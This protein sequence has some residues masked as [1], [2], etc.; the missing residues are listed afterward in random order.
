MIINE[1]MKNE[2][3]ILKQNI[4]SVLEKCN[5]TDLQL[6]NFLR[7]LE[8]ARYNVLSEVKLYNKN[9]EYEYEKIKTIDDEYKAE[10][11]DDEILKIYVPETMPSYKNIKMHTHK[12][13]LLNISE[14]TKPFTGM[15]KDKVFIFI[16]IFDNVLGW[17]VDNKC[18]KPVADGLIMSHVIVD[19]NMTKMIY[20]V[21]GKYS[22]NPHTEIYI[23]DYKNLCSEL[24]KYDT[25]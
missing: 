17:D 14:I 19:D 25:E 12:R 21:E 1:K 11:V 2:L 3:C 15:F 5:L 20:C 4:N 6:E 16:R 23:S 24:K 10:I 8:K 7:T 22:N 13:I 9:V 18:I